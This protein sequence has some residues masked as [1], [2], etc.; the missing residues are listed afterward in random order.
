M[1]KDIKYSG[2]TAQPSDYECHDGEL[3]A[4]LNLISEDNQLKPLFQPALKF[5]LPNDKE[6]VF[7]HETNTYKHYIVLDTS[8]HECFYTNGDVKNDLSLNHI[9]SFTETV[10]IYEIN[11]IGNTLLVLTDDGMHY[12]LWKNNDEGYKHLGTQLPELP[13]SFG[14]QASI[15]KVDDFTIDYD[16]IAQSDWGKGEFTDTNK[17]RVTEQVMAKVN[18]FINEESVNKGKFIFPFFVRYAFRLFDGSITKHS[19]PILMNCCSA[20]TPVCKASPVSKVGNWEQAVIRIFAA[21]HELDVAVIEQSFIDNIKNW[22]DIITSVDVFISLPI[23]LLNQSGQCTCFYRDTDTDHLSDVYSPGKCASVCKHVNADKDVASKRLNE[24][25]AYRDYESMF[26]DTF[27]SEIVADRKFYY[28][29]DLP[30]FSSDEFNKKVKSVSNFYFLKS[31][32]LGN[33]ST[34]RAKIEIADDYLQSLAA[35]EVM[36][37]DYDSHDVLLPRGS[38]V[39]NSR[40]NLIKIQKKLFEGFNPSSLFTY[41]EGTTSN[42]PYIWSTASPQQ[43]FKNT[44]KYVDIYVHIKSDN[45]ESI[46]HTSGLYAFGEDN[47]FGLS[48]TYELGWF[49]YPTSKATSIDIVCNGKIIT[50]KLEPSDV[51]NG[52]IYFSR[53]SMF[54]LLGNAA[55]DFIGQQTQNNIIEI[56]NKIYTSEINNPFYFPV[57]GIN[58]VGTGEILGICAAAKALSQGQFGQFPLYAFTTDGLWALEVSSSGTYS[59]KQPITRDVCINSD[60]ITQLDDAVLFATDR[61]IMLIQGSQ[62]TCITD[63]IFSEYPFNVLELNSIEQLHSKLGHVADTCLPVK[64]F[65]GFLT[66]SRMIYDYVHQRIIV[67]NPTINSEAKQYT[68]A[69]VFSLKSKQ[70]G[71]MYSNLHSAVNSYPDALAMTHDNKL[72]SFSDTDETL[73]RGM[74]ITRPIKLETPDVLKTIDTVIQRGHF[75]KGHV[76]SVLYGSRDLYNWHL[77]WSSKDHYLR[78]F[79][80]SPYKYFRIALL[81]NLASD[82]SIFGASLQFTP[83]L[84]NQPR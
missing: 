74:L 64:P 9:Y 33:L 80:G 47:E 22:S 65:L 62:T 60:S 1:I 14:L 15:K 69:Y 66:N 11:A 67:F 77:V 37:D 20:L 51:L 29:V 45:G 40:L 21:I 8:N 13:M 39:Y 84:T 27:P 34:N 28:Y 71:M 3:A 41:K 31:I 72:V 36:T 56:P 46:V 30:H 10:E 81:C 12:F 57:L 4:S 73:C 53:F 48:D 35:R 42:M 82:E 6:V 59:A 83:R 43:F 76:Q 17:T 32:K 55:P 49:Y 24:G 58:T 61:G 7:V 44:Q 68:Y 2:Y 75:K 78:G 18:K 70:W 38:F 19:A 63:S 52:A 79:R 25:Y 16:G 54:S 5:E 26:N 23:Y 50:Y